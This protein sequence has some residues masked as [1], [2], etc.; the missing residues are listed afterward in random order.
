M[1]STVGFVDDG[2]AVD[3]GDATTAG[4]GAVNVPLSLSASDKA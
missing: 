1:G 3:E 4:L 2:A